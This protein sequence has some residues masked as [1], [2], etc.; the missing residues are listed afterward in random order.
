MTE[1]YLRESDSLVATIQ[2]VNM[3]NGDQRARTEW[4][5]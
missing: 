4:D 5:L 2:Q 3:R 1:K